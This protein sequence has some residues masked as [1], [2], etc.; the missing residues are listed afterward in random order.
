M[1]GGCEDYNRVTDRRLQSI[2][3]FLIFAVTLLDGLNLSIVNIALPEISDCIDISASN[4]SWILNAYT[5]GIATPFLAMVKIA[6]GG[7][8]RPFF[9]SGVLLFSLSSLISGMSD[10]YLMLTVSRFA[11]GIG[12]SMM[13]ATAPIMVIRLLPED[14]KGR[15]MAMLSMS[16]GMSFVVGPLLGGFLMSIASWHWVFL[17]NVPFG[18]IIVLIGYL[19]I[20]HATMKSAFR[21]PDIPSVIYTGIL[22][23]LVLVVLENFIVSSI[24]VFSMVICVVGA[25]VCLFLLMLRLRRTDIDFPLIH[26]EMLN[27]REF[28]FVAGAFF[29][30]TS[31]ATGFL[32]IIPF[33]L[34]ESWGMAEF[35]SGMYISLIS[36]LSIAVSLYGGKWCDTKGCRT[37]AAVSIVLRIVFCLMFMFMVPSWGVIPL[38]IALLIT[39]LSFGLSTVSQNTRIVQ[40]T[41]PRYQA[42][43]SAIMLQIHYVSSSFGVVLYA[44]ILNVISGGVL[45]QTPEMINQGMHITSLLGAVLCIVALIFTMVVRNIVPGKDEPR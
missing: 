42:E 23:S 3:L 6:D 5:L 30:T 11:A 33:F 39:G 27:S 8:V 29:I 13:G 44:I 36:A 40:H 20:P 38:V 43:A 24:P 19:Y 45:D 14:M 22:V 31:V 26:L 12:A 21:F 37:P 1:E 10:T 15:G 4:S 41:I 2:L 16:T 35:T 18:L 28:A 25:F 34:Q 7:K 17:I 32:Y 9:I